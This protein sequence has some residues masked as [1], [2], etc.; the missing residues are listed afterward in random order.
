VPVGLDEGRSPVAD[1]GAAGVDLPR[2][3]PSDRALSPESLTAAIP[4]E[5]VS[6]TGPMVCTTDRTVGRLV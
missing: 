5:P 6:P 2:M 4:E 3:K 1:V